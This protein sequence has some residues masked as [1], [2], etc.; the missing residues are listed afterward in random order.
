MCER[1]AALLAALD[2]ARRKLGDA[3]ALW[4]REPNSFRWQR[5]LVALAAE[6]GHY[7]TQHAER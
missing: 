1:C 2:D 6:A 7:R 3:M 5:Y 4:P